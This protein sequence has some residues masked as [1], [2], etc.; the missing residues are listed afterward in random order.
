MPSELFTVRLDR[1]AIARI[2]AGVE[3]LPYREAAPVIAEFNAQLARNMENPCAS[4]AYAQQIEGVQA[5]GDPGLSQVGHLAITGAPV[6]ARR[7]HYCNSY[8]GQQA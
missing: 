8:K 3:G 2:S 5:C 7:D 6:I 4:C 1:Q